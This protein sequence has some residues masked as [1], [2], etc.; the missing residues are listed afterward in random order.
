MGG[1]GDDTVEGG[2][3]DD[4]L[5]GGSDD[6][7]LDGGTG[8]DIVRGGSGDDTVLGGEGNDTIDGGADADT[9]AFGE[10][11]GNDTITD[12]TDGNDPIRLHDELCAVVDEVLTELEASERTLPEPLTRPMREGA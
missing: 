4:L 3:G 8:N 11:H 10:S 9:F 7:S 6:D 5:L 2:T 1:S 12:F